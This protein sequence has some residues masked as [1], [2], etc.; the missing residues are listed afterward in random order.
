MNPM[1][2]FDPSYP[3]MV[4]DLLND[5]SLE[6]PPV[7]ALSYGRWAREESEGVI[8][9]DGLLLDGWVKPPSVSRLPSE[10]SSAG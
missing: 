9:F 1:N 8:A 7:R 2:E 5:E 10:Q 3:C 6:W 4:H